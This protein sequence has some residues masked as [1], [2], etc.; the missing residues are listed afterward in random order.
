MNHELDQ[1]Y[2]DKLRE[3]K[4]ARDEAAERDDYD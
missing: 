1:V 4:S 2:Q 3:L